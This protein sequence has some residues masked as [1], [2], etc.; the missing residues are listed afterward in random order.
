[1]A[2]VREDLN[3]GSSQTNGVSPKTNGTLLSLCGGALD[4]PQRRMM[5]FLCPTKSPLTR[6]KNAMCTTRATHPKAQCE[7]VTTEGVATGGPFPGEVGG[8]TA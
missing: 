7:M 5:K 2:A 4:A 1:M 8:N 3:E 6:S